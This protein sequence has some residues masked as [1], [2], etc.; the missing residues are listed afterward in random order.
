LVRSFGIALLGS[1]S[2]KEFVRARSA[3]SLTSR[4]TDSLHSIHPQYPSASWSVE[5]PEAVSVPCPSCPSASVFKQ[6]M[7]ARPGEQ[8]R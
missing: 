8:I 7:P 3:R 1:L 6:L 2:P 5:R 4:G